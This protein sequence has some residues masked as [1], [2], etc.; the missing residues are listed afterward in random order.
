M[1]SVSTV[2]FV[3]LRL[4]TMNKVKLSLSLAERLPLNAINSKKYASSFS[5]K[6]QNLQS[7]D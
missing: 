6:V 1:L 3:S 7:V 4:V 2:D 5:P